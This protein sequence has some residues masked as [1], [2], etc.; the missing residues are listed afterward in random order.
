M[1][2]ETLY[3]KC[4]KEDIGESILLT[5]SPERVARIAELMDEAQTIAQNREFITVT[6]R[7][8]G[9]RLTAVSSGI[10]SS[11]AAIAVEELVQLGA[12]RIVR[13]G[14]TMGVSAPLGAYVLSTGAARFE[15]TSRYYLDPAYPAVPDWSLSQ[16]IL[17]SGRRHGLEIRLGITATYD[18][19]YPSMAAGL[20]GHEALNKEEL[21]T[22]QVTA[23]DMETGLLYI[24][25]IR[26]RFAAVS[27]CLVTNSFAPFAALDA[28]V[29]SAGEEKLIKTVLEGLV[30]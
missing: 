13:V 18:A 2:E 26:L 28:A 9:E 8:Q 16:R 23:V 14:T 27:F 4:K 7:Y 6:G 20:M 5:G 19:F 30:S 10:G 11:S 17:G 21:E 3:L 15:G 1:K 22:A 12:K 25:G 24:M 29:R